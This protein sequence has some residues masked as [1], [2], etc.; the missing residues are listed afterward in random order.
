MEICEVSDK[1][2]SCKEIVR[3]NIRYLIELRAV[4]SLLVEWR[5]IR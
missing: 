5:G 4:K 2:G 3:R 1:V